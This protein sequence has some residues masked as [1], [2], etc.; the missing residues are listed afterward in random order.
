MQREL[1]PFL[2]VLPF[3]RDHRDAAR[4]ISNQSYIIDFLTTLANIAPHLAIVIYEISPR[5]LLS[6]ESSLNTG[7]LYTK[8]ILET[9][10]YLFSG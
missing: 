10:S 9:S 2:K 7:L 3:L 1:S 6:Y 8:G 4:G 5:Q